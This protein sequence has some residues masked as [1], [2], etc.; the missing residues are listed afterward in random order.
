M[1]AN[2][3]S[4]FRA[5]VPNFSAV[6]SFLHRNAWWALYPTGNLRCVNLVTGL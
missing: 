4:L 3:E 2:L 5:N 1:L 6:G